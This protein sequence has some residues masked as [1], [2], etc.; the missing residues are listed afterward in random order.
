M[1]TLAAEEKTPAQWVEQLGSGKMEEREQASAALL[2]L[3][4]GAREQVRAALDSKDAEVQARARDL[5]ET[6]RWDVIPGAEKDIAQFLDPPPEDWKT[7]GL[8]ANFNKKYGLESLRLIAEFH[9]ANREETLYRFG[10]M[11]VVGFTPPRQIAGFITRSEPEQRRAYEDLLGLFPPGA[12]GLHLAGIIVQIQSALGNNDKALAHGRDA[13]VAAPWMGADYDKLIGF[14]ATAAQE[15]TMF[16]NI[17][18]SAPKDLAAEA[19]PNRLCARLRFYSALMARMGKKEEIDAL[20]DA[21]DGRTG[22]ADD[23]HLRPLTETL[24][25]AGLPARALKALAGASGALSLYMRSNIELKAGDKAAAGADWD[26]A[27][28]AA[29]SAT[30]NEFRKELWLN[31]GGLMHDWHDERAESFFQKVLASPPGKTA[32]DV[33]ACFQMGA[34][35]EEQ[36]ENARAIGYYEK[37][38]DLCKE[39]HGQYSTAAPD[40][41]GIQIFLLNDDAAPIREKVKK[42]KALP[43]EAD[44]APESSRKSA[45]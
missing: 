32:F 17:K 3:G 23:A 33:L 13:A 30:T 41:H 16:D 2:A 5:W 20:C 18:Q 36:Q 34:L 22:K 35:M 19:D 26:A 40:N 6:L 9:A 31:L 29:D 43:P 12:N 42:L 44:P 14:C 8:W 1:D 39:L 25:A 7:R 45:S 10:L 15:G 21:A 28:K 24:L 11:L 38:L 37:G 4:S 27:V